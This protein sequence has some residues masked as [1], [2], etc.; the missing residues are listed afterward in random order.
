MKTTRTARA[1]ITIT[2]AAENH[3]SEILQDNPT[4]IG[5]RFSLKKAGCAGMEYV[6]ELV[7]NENMQD[8]KIT[9]NQ[10]TVYIDRNALLFLL[11]TEIDFE[12]TKFRSGFVFNNP[13]Q[14]SACGCGESVELRPA[15]QL[16]I[17]K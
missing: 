11:G 6:V 17:D 7:E 5:I 10:V 14:L 12:E 4:A 15:D 13:N 3:I 16:H 1:I 8:E 2:A 9:F